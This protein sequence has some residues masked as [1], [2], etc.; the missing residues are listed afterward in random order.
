MTRIFSILLLLIMTSNLAVS[1]VSQLHAGAAY[2]YA[3]MGADDAEEDNKT[4]K[5]K[6]HKSCALSQC[7]LPG[8]SGTFP[9]EKAKRALITTNDRLISELFAF[10]PELP[11]EA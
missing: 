1:V 4:E 10:M 7:I 3:E 11:P 9:L 5:E 2:A 8:H 6:E